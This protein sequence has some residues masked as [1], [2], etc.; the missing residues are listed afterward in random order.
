ML[1]LVAWPFQKEYF[2][3]R[4]ETAD[5]QFSKR[6]SLLEVSEA[7]IVRVRAEHVEQ[8]L[9]LMQTYC[10]FYQASPSDAALRGL[11]E[12]LLA[13]PERAGIQLLARDQDGTALGSRRSSGR[14]RR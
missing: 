2:K 13:D 1:M 14:S 6:I 9:P 10:A 7:E 3:L 8:L 5:R 12:A 11:A 4:P